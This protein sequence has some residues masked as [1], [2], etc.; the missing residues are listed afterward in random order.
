[1]R[2]EIITV[3]P[4]IGE[5]IDAFEADPDKV[6]PPVRLVGERGAIPCNTVVLVA[7]GLSVCRHF[8]V[9]PGRRIK[10]EIEKLNRPLPAL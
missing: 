6:V 9:V 10:L 7:L 4:N 1:M 3:E 5:I 2:A 8:D